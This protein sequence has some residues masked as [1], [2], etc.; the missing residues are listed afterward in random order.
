MLADGFA[1]A[2]AVHESESI[3]LACGRHRGDFDKPQIQ[4]HL[5]TYLLQEL[6]RTDWGER[7]MSSPL[8]P[9][10]ISNTRQQDDQGHLRWNLS[11]VHV[12]I[13]PLHSTGTCLWLGN[14]LLPAKR[15]RAPLLAVDHGA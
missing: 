9:A 11:T 6:L 4:S 10:P 1:D 12:S 15:V 5:S 2:L 3:M 7:H 8:Y 14:I 13:S